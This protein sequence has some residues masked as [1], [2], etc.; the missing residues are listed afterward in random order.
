MIDKQQDIEYE[1]LYKPKAKKLKPDW[2]NAPTIEKLN[3]D[4]RNS[5]PDFGEHCSNVIK[6]LE[7][8]DGVL[9]EKPGKQS[10]KPGVKYLCLVIKVVILKQWETFR[11]CLSVVVI[12]QRMKQR[13]GILWDTKSGVM[14]ILRQG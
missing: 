3:E 2:K 1:E 8:R 12:H 9:K 6:W 14:K 11:T 7:L 5:E 13:N 10:M 4:I